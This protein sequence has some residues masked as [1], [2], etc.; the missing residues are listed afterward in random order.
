MK[1][2]VHF[3]MDGVL[4]DWDLGIEA[5]HGKSYDKLSH[6]EKSKFWNAGAA[7]TGFFRGL[8]TIPQ[9]EELLKAITDIDGVDVRVLTSTGGGSCHYQILADKAHWLAGLDLPAK[10]TFCAVP[11]AWIKKQIVTERSF[12]IDDNQKTVDEWTAGGGIGWLF[13]REHTA[14]TLEWISTVRRMAG[15]GR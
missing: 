5:M 12:L 13:S 8:C 1:P 6:A 11:G 3:D 4:A 15:R 2:V 10:V 7:E 9:G 14:R